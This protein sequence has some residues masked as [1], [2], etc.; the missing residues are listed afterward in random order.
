MY[1]KEVR[2]AQL[3]RADALKRASSHM[4]RCC[5]D[6][7]KDITVIEDVVSCLSRTVFSKQQQC[8]S[9]RH[10]FLSRTSIFAIAVVVCSGSMH[11]CES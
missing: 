10:Q 6:V 11:N 5:V 3:K 7:I 1:T 4:S 8:R 2:A 9:Q